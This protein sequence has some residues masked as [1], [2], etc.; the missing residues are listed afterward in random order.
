MPAG[1]L[2]CATALGGTGWLQTPSW[3]RSRHGMGHSWVLL[4]L[5]PQAEW[6]LEGTFG[7]GHSI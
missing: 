4:V 1:S 5:V 3:G 2:A 6:H 7:R